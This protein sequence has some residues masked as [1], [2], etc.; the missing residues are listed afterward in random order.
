MEGRVI[1]LLCLAFVF[2]F[3]L[4]MEF[5]GLS[6]PMPMDGDASR[7]VV[8]KVELKMLKPGIPTHRSSTSRSRS[9]TYQQ[10]KF[11]VVYDESVTNSSMSVSIMNLTR[12][13]VDL[14]SRQLQ[15]KQ[16]SQDYIFDRPCRTGSYVNYNGTVVN[17]TCA[18]Y[19]TTCGTATLPEHHLQPCSTC[20]RDENGTEYDCVP[21]PGGPAERGVS[22]VHYVLYVTAIAGGPCQGGVIGFASACYLDPTLNRPIAGFINIC[23]GATTIREDLQVLVQ[24]EIYHALGFS[25]SLYALFRDQNG[26]PLTPLGDDGFPT[27]FNSGGY[28]QWSDRVARTKTLDWDI[29]GGQI[30]RNVTIMVT[31]NLV[32]EAREYYGCDTIEG[33]E[34]E[35]DYGRFPSGS[36]L[37]HFESRLMP[38]ESMGPAL[39]NGRTFSRFTLAF[40]ED[41]GWYKVNYDLADPFTWGRDLGCGFVNK[42]C[43]WW[44]DTQRNR[45]LS[46]SPYCENSLELL[47][48]V[49]SNA[50]FCSNIKH[51]EPLPDQYQYFDSLPGFNET[52]ISSVGGAFMFDDH[53]PT[54]FPLG[55]LQTNDYRRQTCDKEINECDSDPCNNG[56]TCSDIITG[57]FCTCTAEY[58]GRHCDYGKTVCSTSNQCAKNEVCKDGL[59]S[60]GHGRI[61]TEEGCQIPRRFDMWFQITEVNG[62]LAIYPDTF[63]SSDEIIRGELEYAIFHRLSRWE[64][65]VDSVF[66]VEIKSF[67]GSL[68]VEI[69][70]VLDAGSTPDDVMIYDLMTDSYLFAAED[71]SSGYTSYTVNVSSIVVQDIDECSNSSLNECSPFARCTNT[72]GG[73]NCVCLSGYVDATGSSGR[74]CADINE[75]ISQPCFN[76]GTCRNFKDRFTCECAPGYE[77]QNCET[78]LESCITEDRCS[79]INHEF[80]SISGLCTCKQGYRRGN[81][82]CQAIGIYKGSLRFISLNGSP[83]FYTSAL[84]DSLR[85]GFQQLAQQLRGTLLSA[86]PDILD[87]S[88]TSFRAGSIIAEFDLFVVD[89]TAKVAITTAVME[90]LG[91]GTLIAG[92]DIVGVDPNSMIIEDQNEC[93]SA[94]LNDCSLVAACTNEPGTFSCACPLEY[95]DISPTGAGPGRVCEKDQVEKTDSMITIVIISIVIGVIFVLFVALLFLFICCQISANKSKKTDTR[96]IHNDHYRYKYPLS[97][98][99]PQYRNH[100]GPIGTVSNA[101]YGFD[102]PPSQHF[103]Q[104]HDLEF[105][106]H[107]LGYPSRPRLALSYPVQ[108]HLPLEYPGHHRSA[109][110]Y[111]DRHPFAV[112]YPNRFRLAPEYS[113]NQGRLALEYPLSNPVAR[114]Y[115]DHHRNEFIL[116]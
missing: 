101:V 12:E 38:T 42:S 111:P 37:S 27:E 100:R 90:G 80:C 3:G 76:G 22:D 112:K 30:E 34:L 25:P 16:E 28:L 115:P 91:D 79:T 26:D 69:D 107:R 62:S 15:V 86:I 73:Y 70:I 24:H 46:L 114:A 108:Y 47:C 48:D 19:V 44:M 10:M 9:S 21:E 58:A 98:D 93:I 102:E 43:K 51:D 31:P 71:L 65:F 18:D 105:G 92:Q 95:T 20:K 77:G 78:M 84:A 32:K 50:A 17:C 49:E 113:A 11:E 83:L 23:P 87:V 45:G 13:T 56:A 52:D 110:V 96:Q 109:L 66:S 1:T 39:T 54:I 81:G 29:R 35:D 33:V 99:R 36:A 85:D 68:G 7:C 64:I 63:K 2:D 82:I 5:P 61:R 41:T 104:G 94:E 57:Y 40:L 59:C 106:R 60:C 72:V 8:P 75:C 6:E 67:N 88:F 55:R 89:G 53:C 97:L 74:L 103:D 14:I 116:R 4:S